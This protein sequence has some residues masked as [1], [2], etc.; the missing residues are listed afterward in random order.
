MDEGIVVAG[1]REKIGRGREKGREG[2]K[3]N[4]LC[5]GRNRGGYRKKTKMINN[6]IL[7]KE[8]KRPRKR[9]RRK[10]KKEKT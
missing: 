8:G 6:K 4:R 2:S 10:Q 7:I 1:E 5:E 3:E 9:K